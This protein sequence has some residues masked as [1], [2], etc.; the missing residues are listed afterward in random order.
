MSA[1]GRRAKQSSNTLSKKVTTG[2]EPKFP[3]T[4]S[5]LPDGIPNAG[6]GI[7]SPEPVTSETVF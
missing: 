6:L 5:V 3:A 4:A 2:Y 7:V 1:M